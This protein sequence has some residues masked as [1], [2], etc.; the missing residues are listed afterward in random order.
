MNPARI[1]CLLYPSLHFIPGIGQ[2]TYLEWANSSKFRRINW[3]G[4]PIE[5][6]SYGSGA[7]RNFF[8]SLRLKPVDNLCTNNVRRQIECEESPHEY[9]K[10]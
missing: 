4:R 9:A 1:H 10:K 6:D 5:I 8:L 3:A 7:L 2:M